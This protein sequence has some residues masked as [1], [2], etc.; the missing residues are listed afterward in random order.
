M[1]AAAKA[2]AEMTATPPEPPQQDSTTEQQQRA[3][4]KPSQQPLVSSVHGHRE[5]RDNPW[6]LERSQ[7][8]GGETAERHHGA[9]GYYDTEEDAKRR[10]YKRR[11]E[12]ED[13]AL[14]ASSERFEAGA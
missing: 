5:H 2:P 12:L 1:G 6:L 14:S 13:R 11:L 3:D 9:T 8:P 4:S 7:Q 10:N